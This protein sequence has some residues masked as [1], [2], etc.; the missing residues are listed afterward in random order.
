MKVKIKRAPGCD[1]SLPLPSYQTEGAAGV[2]LLAHGDYELDEGEEARIRTGVCFEIPPGFEG[3]VRGRSGLAFKS[4]VIAI[5]SPGTI[6]S[7]YRGEVMV[8]LVNGGKETFTI[9]HGD[10]VAQMVFAPVVRAVFEE[11]EELSDSTRGSSGFGS[12]GVKP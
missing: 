1:R 5:H 9:N 3:Q 8:L 2:D 6:D 12:T 4:M 11:S 7:D 10:R